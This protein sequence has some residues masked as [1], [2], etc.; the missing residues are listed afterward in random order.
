VIYSDPTNQDTDG[1]GTQDGFE[2]YS[3]RTSPVLADTD[4]DQISDTDEV[5]ARNRDPRIADLPLHGINIGDVRLQI[6]ERFTYED[7]QGNTVTTD[8]SS[9]VTLTHGE[10]KTRSISGSG[11]I[12]A[13]YEAEGGSTIE[14][15]P[16]PYSSN[17]VGFS[18]GAA[19][20]IS[21][22]SATESQRVR[23]QSFGKAKELNT[24]NTVTREIVGARI[25]ADL[26]IEN[27]SNLAFSISNL[28]VTVLQRSRESTR[29]FIPVA[30]L[31]ANSS[32]ISGNQTTFN[33]G[34][35]TPARGPIVFTSRDVFPNLIDEMMQLPADGLIFEVVNYD[36]T[37]EYGRVFTFANQI[38][39]D[40]TGGI[41][42]DSGDGQIERHLLATALQPDPD[43]VINGNF[44][45]GFNGDGSPKGIPIDFALQDIMKL[46]KNATVADGIVAGI[47]QMANS[48]A[49]GDDVQVIPPGTTGVSVGSIVISAGQNGVLDTASLGDDLIE[50]TTGYETS[51]TCDANSENA[52]EICSDDNQCAASLTGGGFC[53]G[54]ETLVRFGSQRTGDFNRQWVVLTNSQLPAGAEFSQLMLKPGEDI[55][56]A[57]VQ[58]LD[59]DGIFAREEFLSGS[60]DSSTDR[61]RNAD[62]GK[63][64]NPLCV[65]GCSL[66]SPAVMM[67]GIADSKDTDQDGLG[68]FAEIRVGWKVSADGGQL[69]QVFPSPRLVD[70]DG[71]GLFDPVEQDLR[72]FCN[73]PTDVRVD[74]LCRFQS[75]SPVNQADAIAII[76]G[77]DGTADSLAL[78]DDEQLITQGVTGL[79]YATQII[80]PGANGIIDTPL[81][82][83]NEYQSVQSSLR[84]P[85]ATNPIISDTDVDG[86]ED[87]A[88]LTGFDIGL[89][90]RDGGDG[91]ANTQAIGDDI[92]QAFLNGPVSPG[93]IVVLPGPNGSI[94]STP[95]ADDILSSASSV[96]TDPLRRDTDA[97]LVTDGRER[98]LGGNPTNPDDGA[99]FRDSDQDGLSDTEESVLGWLVNVNGLPS[100]LVLSNPSRPDSDF[101]GLPDF[102][103]RVLKTDP[104][105]P[106]TDGDGI[107]DFDEIAGSDFEQF[108]GLDAQF[109][110]FSIDGASSRQYGT[111]PNNAN[112]DTDGISDYDELLKG[113]RVLLGGESTFRQVYTNPLVADTDL[114]GVND[115]LEWSRNP[116]TDAT[117]P[118]TDDDGRSDGVERSAGSDPLVP[119]V[120]IT[121]TYKKLIMNRITDVGGSGN[122][123]VQWFFMVKRPGDPGNG[124]LL[125]DAADCIF[126]TAECGFRA[127]LALPSGQFC[128][129]FQAKPNTDYTLNLGL[130]RVSSGYYRYRSGQSK[131]VLKEGESF[132]VNGIIW[133]TDTD[134]SLANYPDCGL[135]P[136]YTPTNVVGGCTT[137]FDENFKFEDF[138]D[139]GQ[140]SFPFPDGVGTAESCDWTIEVEVTSQ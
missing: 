75:V 110:G 40:R 113:Y 97:D 2:F 136:F 44:V 31:V 118:D 19:I 35:F 57:F 60:T 73:K 116:P 108:F 24:S 139:G 10:N 4:G 121:V 6:D 89:S 64:V 11:N 3:F 101:D 37:D 66:V 48:I 120:S 91:T 131:F 86:I 55:L 30:T 63:L 20:Q 27:R 23:E 61:F 115:N 88:E 54:P 78:N 72:I 106:D 39:R 51:L 119:D 1:D 56:L 103:E 129:Q 16:K 132:S 94:E 79:T 104:N 138:Q 9:S 59:Q 77:T 84:I 102:A 87:F 81:G 76:A 122:S 29:R 21:T 96:E 90:I 117:D 99:E 95:G 52:R 38:A 107:R 65:G 112:S 58:D 14:T 12:A 105:N 8:S 15:T 67:D 18:V 98:D 33:L 127:Y 36:I 114:D 128:P 74:A 13:M 7:A 32:L 41:I 133:E 69:T 93:G 126:S 26:T 28:E 85:P 34:P 125:S 22:E 25:D 83:N 140:A 109:P 62:F 43:Q 42:I 53:K 17:K 124:I 45:G 82:G 47:D 137:R 135:P 50:V 46:A 71:D 123:E 5:L 111:L 49:Q 130:G 100:R 134:L 92:Q 68:D 80:G 70:S